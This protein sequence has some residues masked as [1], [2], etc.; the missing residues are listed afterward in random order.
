MRLVDADNL[1][2]GNIYYIEIIG[3]LLRNLQKR[4]PTARGK[5]YG[6]CGPL[7][8]T[9]LHR[10]EL[11]YLNGKLGTGRCYFLENNYFVFP[12]EDVVYYESSGNIQLRSFTSQVLKDITNDPDFNQITGINYTALRGNYSEIPLTSLKVGVEYFIEVERGNREFT[13]K[14][15]MREIS[16]CVIGKFEGFILD[17]GELVE[18]ITF[19]PYGELNKLQFCDIKEVEQFIKEINVEV[20]RKWLKLSQEARENTEKWIEMLKTSVPHKPRWHPTITFFEPVS[21]GLNKIFTAQ[22]HCMRLG[23]FDFKVRNILNFPEVVDAESPYEDS[24]YES[25]EECEFCSIMGGTRK[26]KYPKRLRSYKIKSRRK[27][28]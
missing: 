27:L 5:F 24:G 2:I 19:V 6:I 4:Y 21:S 18:D 14:K 23:L 22:G 26:R 10:W 13:E 8:N 25:Q 17:S 20:S 7:L 12:R 3:D 28:S 1:V 9:N 15:N 16:G 11:K